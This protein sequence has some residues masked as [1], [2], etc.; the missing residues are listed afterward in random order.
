MVGRFNNHLQLLHVFA[1]YPA[2][3]S[4]LFRDTEVLAMNS[5]ILVLEH[6]RNV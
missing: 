1:L 3:V 6:L 2:P 4:S 5:N